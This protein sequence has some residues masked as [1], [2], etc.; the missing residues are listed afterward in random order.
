MKRYLYISFNIWSRESHH[1]INIVSDILLRKLNFC[2]KI[3][4]V[5]SICTL[6]PDSSSVE[7]IILYEFNK[8][9]RLTHQ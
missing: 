3:I 9:P 2:I 5:H 1:L 6:F 4:K 7:S 8:V